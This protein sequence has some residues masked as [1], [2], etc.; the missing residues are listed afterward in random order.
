MN[1]DPSHAAAV[2]AW[3]RQRY[4]ALRRDIGWLTLAGL[5]WL[6]PGLNSLGTDAAADIVLPGGP[7]AAGTITLT[8]G[9][10]VAEGEIAGET[11]IP[12][13]SDEDGEPTMLELGQLRLCLIRRGERLALRTWDTEA[14]QRRT[15]AGIPHYPVDTTWRVRARLTRAGDRMIRVPDVLGE[16]TDEASPGSVVFNVDGRELRL[17]A[18]EGGAAGELWLIFGDATNGGT[19]YG[20]GRFLYTAA[21]EA[22]DTLWIDF[23]RVYNPPCVFSPYA[24]CPLPPPQNR[25]SIAI[26][27]GEQLYEAH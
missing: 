11:A 25:L 13:M 27:A 9:R 24:T 5:D 4:A 10:A 6:H 23:N 12:M 20:G 15:F 21:P 14:A 2:E 16:V 1:A 3:R 26:E 22:D 18:L 8:G 17:D 7:A 19:T